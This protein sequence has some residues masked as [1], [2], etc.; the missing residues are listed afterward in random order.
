MY[1]GKVEYY[2]GAGKNQG[3]ENKSGW[4][5]RGKGITQGKKNEVY[6]FCHLLCL[7]KRTIMSFS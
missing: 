4:P 2:W 6:E 3:G 1:R 7:T 5:S